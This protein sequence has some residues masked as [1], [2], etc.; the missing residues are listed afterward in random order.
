MQTCPPSRALLSLPLS[1]QGFVFRSLRRHRRQSFLVQQAAPH[2]IVVIPHARQRP[3]EL[4]PQRREPVPRA[5]DAVVE[6]PTSQRIEPPRLD[7]IPA[8]YPLN[9]LR[10]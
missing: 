1:L 5:D 6:P 2:L 4:A 9:L 3:G 8:P 7:A 10:P